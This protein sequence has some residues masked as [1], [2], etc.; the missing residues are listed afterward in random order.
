MRKE[1]IFLDSS[2]VMEYV[3][4]FGV[5]RDMKWVRHYKQFFLIGLIVE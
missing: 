5:V 4:P 2:H 1:G 3:V